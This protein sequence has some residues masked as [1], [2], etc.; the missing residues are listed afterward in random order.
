[1]SR[2]LVVGIGVPGFVAAQ[3][4]A[5]PGLRAAHLASTIAAEGHSVLL[6]AVLDGH[7]AA[8]VVAGRAT[9]DAARVGLEFTSERD[10]MSAAMRRRIEEFAPDAVVGVTVYAAALAVRLH[11]GLPLWADVFGDLMAEAQAKAAR[12]GNDW[13]LVHFWTLLEIVLEGAD[14]FSAVSVAQSH[15]LI[16]QLGLA[17]RLSSRTAGDEMVATIPCAAE[18]P[19]EA[20]DRDAAS[21]D[22]DAARRDLG[23]GLDEF[24]LLVSG[25]VNT[26]CDVETLCR[27]LED[28]MS[29]D[30]RLR[31][32]VT[33]GPI[34][35]HDEASHAALLA[36]LR[37]IDA[38]PHGSRGGAVADVAG[39]SGAIA[40]PRV[41][42]LGSPRAS[43][44]G[45]P[46]VSVLGWIESTRLAAVYAACDLALHIERPLYE[47]LLG[48]E[49]RVVEWLAHGLPVV[50][51][52]LS[53]T[54]K[55][56]LAAGL[57]LACRPGDARDLART[58]RDAA[59]R[60]AELADTG[61]RGRDWVE[62]HR[63]PALTASPLL[64]WCADPRAA[65][66]RDGA[67]LVRLGLLTHPETSVEML[68]SYVAALPARELARR[69]LRWIARRMMAAAAR[70][71]ERIRSLMIARPG[72]RA[73]A[74]GG[75]EVLA[76]DQR[77]SI[78][79][80]D[81]SRAGARRSLWG[82]ALLLLAATTIA[83]GCMPHAKQRPA[84]RPNILLLSI[85]T[86]RFDHVG[87]YGY[88]LRPS[89]TPWIDR[90]AA[91]GV[92]FEQA[93]TSA[94]ET[95]PALASLVTGV[96]QDR[97][98]VMYNRARLGRDSHTLAERLKEA[99]YATAAF[100]GNW[101]VDAKHGFGQGFDRTEV[102]QPGGQVTTTIDDKLVARVGNFLREPPAGAPWFLWVHMMDPHG[103]YDSA[104]VWWSR[105]FDY[106]GASLAH[107]GE[108][109]V[110]DS[111]FGLGVIPRYQKID[112]A[113]LLSDYV[114]RYDGDIRFTDS[115]VGSLLGMLAAT[116]AADNTIVVLVADHGES[117]VEHRELLQ[118][119][120]FVHETTTH[121]PLLISWPAGLPA[122]ARVRDEAC[123]VDIVPT[124]LD[125]AGVKAA[126]DDF[127]GRSL[128]SALRL[129]PAVA[130]P[131]AVGAAGDRALRDA[132]CFSVGPRAN[133]PFALRTARYRMILTPAGAPTDPRAPKGTVS[134]E[135]ERSE[136]FDLTDD[137]GETV[138]LA[139]ARSDLVDQMLQP[140]AKLRARFRANGWRW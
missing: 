74:A 58:L 115:Q 9:Q 45:R 112:G 16:G 96:Y 15:A 44:L 75:S 93:F 24:V 46:R 40:A 139:A 41:S 20:A 1:M 51:T 17:G 72:R 27:G 66:D 131:P 39:G 104:P 55:E 101:L 13:S 42:L 97:H 84:S 125:L 109:P 37:A 123:S 67:R 121:V 110:S 86:L 87:A 2:I 28:A 118:H 124:L 64:R 126:G 4:H 90:L 85:D 61:R 128:V 14:R 50:T 33:G 76:H 48:G 30:P 137:P 69:G 29:A 7:E 68:E 19:A 98:G 111:N 81:D 95:A 3:R 114:R 127:D 122:P 78:V 119:G 133:H 135:A 116:G 136:I 80:D 8:P 35:G 70:G 5:G 25:G 6:L 89:P 65:R 107:D 134:S 73:P 34:P 60:R 38:P 43:V 71:V 18:C 23:F 102:V 36:G 10:L 117:L 62:A 49:N 91:H 53:E 103:P 47:R 52:G 12:T 94:P 82:L 132:G 130:S 79:D 129:E 108:F 57:A 26:W 32:V 77:R 56:L 138:N 105:P 88:A 140:L 59:P 63:G 92:L 106:A 11:L 31:L 83:G 21:L 99:G 113:K 100:V 120:W 22:R 54:G